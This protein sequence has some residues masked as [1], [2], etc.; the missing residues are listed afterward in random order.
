MRRT[1]R[2]RGRIVNFDNVC[3]C[4]GA[5]IAADYV[6]LA[7]QDCGSE[8]LPSSGHR[9]QGLPDAG[10]LGRSTTHK[11]EAKEQSQYAGCLL[12][13][14]VLCVQVLWASKSPS[15]PS[16]RK[17]SARFPKLFAKILQEGLIDYDK[18]TN[19]GS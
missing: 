16:Y 19:L 11:C 9:R 8:F 10:N 3:R 5:I 12:H 7:V 18:P 15:S 6:N 4:A 17:T 2:V 13:K 14:H 1:P